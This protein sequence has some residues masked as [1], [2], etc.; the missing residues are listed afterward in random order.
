MSRPANTLGHL[1][2]SPFMLTITPVHSN[3]HNRGG[4]FVKLDVTQLSQS[5]S[6][7]VTLLWDLESMQSYCNLSDGAGGLEAEQAAAWANDAAFQAGARF[8]LPLDVCEWVARSILAAWVRDEVQE[9]DWHDSQP[10]PMLRGNRP[11]AILATLAF[12]YATRVFDTEEILGACR[13][14]PLF[15]S[16]CDG[17]SP[18]AQD[19]IRFRR[20]NRGRL[21]AVLARILTRAVQQRFDLPATPLSLALKRRVLENAIG[22]LDIAR[23]M[24][25]DE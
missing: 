18:F 1:I 20:E 8:D 3:E 7:F 17:A 15:R 22:R 4:Q 5:R 9:L 13:Q 2:F 6:C 16:L 21:V 10:M 24:E 23:H 14:D 12:A 11:Q 19:L 25:T